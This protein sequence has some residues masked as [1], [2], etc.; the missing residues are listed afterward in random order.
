LVPY[1]FLAAGFVA[2]RLEFGQVAQAAA[3][4]S[5]LH[6][7]LSIIVSSFPMLANYANVVVHLSEFLDRSSRSVER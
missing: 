1:W 6:E 4:F 2:G 3:V 7:A 5:S